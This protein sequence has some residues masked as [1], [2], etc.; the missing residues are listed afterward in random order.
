M[1]RHLPARRAPASLLAAVLALAA[2]SS[3]DAT[4]SPSRSLPDDTAA[5]ATPA[6]APTAPARTE[7]PTESPTPSPPAPISAEPPPIAL[8]QV[9]SGLDSPIGITG[10][11]AGRLYV[12]E[13]GGRIVIL[14]PDGGTGSFVDL[15]DR[16]GS[17]GERGLLGVAFHPGWPE[18]ERLFVHYT[19]LN[20]NTVLSELAASANGDAP[21]ADPGSERILLQVEQPFPNHNGG[22]LAFD[23]DGY[24]YMALGDGGSRGD[25][26]GHGQNPQTL[27]GSILRLHVEADD[28]YAIPSDNPFA[29]GGGAPEVF[30]Y[31]LR[32]PWRFSFDAATGDLWI[33][34]VG[35]LGWEE[36]NRLSPGEAAGANLGWNVMEG[37]H[38]FSAANCSTEGL[39]LPV[40]EYSRDQGNCAVTGGH[41]YRG[42]ALP[43]LR[44]WYLFTDYC[45]GRLFGI[46]SDASPPAAGESI[47]LRLLLETGLRVTAFGQD[48]DGE[49]YL[50]DIAGGGIYRI[51]AG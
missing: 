36:I 40:A 50:A 18:V 29:D 3:P 14:E 44:G 48:A 41:V 8:E 13:R 11:P 28:G 33:A 32:N 38:C 25:P 10:D 37:L 7:T 6:P 24:L 5:P 9:A 49:L 39:V 46:P 42:E 27:L 35:Q 16:V 23:P 21:A 1:S 47:E 17:G 4:P 43:D 15:G 12:N 2:C 34:D 22:Q 31:G 19:D 45:S 51:V 26:L 30:I 20:G